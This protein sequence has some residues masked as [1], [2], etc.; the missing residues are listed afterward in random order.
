MNVND[1]TLDVSSRLDCCD[2]N[3]APARDN[4]APG[5]ASRRDRRKSPTSRARLRV[6]E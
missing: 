6:K 3:Y 5:R 4:K 2:M 1:M